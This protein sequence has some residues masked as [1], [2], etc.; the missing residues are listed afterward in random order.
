M[1]NFSHFKYV[2]ARSPIDSFKLAFDILGLLRAIPSDDALESVVSVYNLHGFI[3]G[4][5]YSNSG[6]LPN[7]IRF[8]SIP[9]IGESCEMELCALAKIENNGTTY[10]FTNNEY[11]FNAMTEARQ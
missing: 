5:V 8:F 9:S 7:K 11:F 4:Y 10:V 1:Y 6:E 2:I 3:N